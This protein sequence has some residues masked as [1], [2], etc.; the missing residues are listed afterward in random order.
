MKN[1]RKRV[2]DT[3]QMSK[4]IPQVILL[5]IAMKQEKAAIMM[6]VTTLVTSSKMTEKRV[7]CSSHSVEAQNHTPSNMK[8]NDAITI[9]DIRE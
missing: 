8:L 6:A 9:A 2:N 5:Q 7:C 4:S 1:Q 3:E